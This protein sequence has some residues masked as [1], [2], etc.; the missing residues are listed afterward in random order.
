MEYLMIRS[1]IVW[2][3]ICAGFAT[4]VTVAI[5]DDSGPWDEYSFADVIL[6]RQRRDDSV[7]IRAAW[8][9]VVRSSSPGLDNQTDAP[10]SREEAARFLGFVEGRLHLSL[11][12]WW[13]EAVLAGK[14]RGSVV[15]FELSLDDTPASLTA[16]E[17]NPFSVSSHSERW[18]VDLSAQDLVVTEIPEVAA[19]VETRIPSEI[20]GLEKCMGVGEPYGV[21]VDRRDGIVMVGIDQG[22]ADFYQVTA[23]DGES[24]EKMWSSDI[25]LRVMGIGGSPR[26]YRHDNAFVQ[27]ESTIYVIGVTVE[28]A[29]LYGYDPETGEEVFRFET[30]DTHR[31]EVHEPS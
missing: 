7:A 31:M 17:S 29:Y 9:V 14:R 12:E 16:A 18:S 4:Q 24:L 15:V 30:F 23:I 2:T 20:L 13:Q 27:S 5:C 19:V 26:G 8:E 11:P 25:R 22:P 21:I 1:V 3:L 10:L 28:R 6:L